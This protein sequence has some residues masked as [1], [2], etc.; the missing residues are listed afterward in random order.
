MSS[1]YTMSTPN[2]TVLCCTCGV[3]MEWNPSNMC[4]NCLTTRVDVSEGISKQG[5]LT[6]CRT[7]ERYLLP[8][9]NWVSAELES[10]ELLSICIKKTKGLNKVKLVDAG[11]VW[12]EPHSRRVKTKLTVQKEVFPN[13]ILQQS[14]VIEFVVDACQCEGCR[15][16]MSEQTWKASVQ[17]RQKVDHKKT[18]FY[19]EQ[20]ILKHSAHTHTTNIKEVPDGMDFYYQSKSH[21]MKF[22]D[23][24][25]C[26]VPIKNK[27]AAEKL[28]SADVKSATANIKTTYS[29]E[30]APVCKDD[31]VCLPRKYSMSLG[32]FGP[33]VLLTHI[34]NVIRM[35]DPF[36]LRTVEIA[37]TMYWKTPFKSLG[38][39]RHAREFIVL[40][41]EP[42]GATVGKFRLARAEIA[43]VSD[44]GA[45]DTTFHVV[46]HLGNVLHP[47][48]AVLG[49]DF[50]SAN[51]ND[52]GLDSWGEDLSLP[53]VVLVK[54]VYPKKAKKR[55]W[56]LKTLAAEPEEDML[57]RNIVER[58]REDYEGFLDDLE[59][60][61]DLRCKINMYKDPVAAQEIGRGEGDMEDE[62]SGAADEE[63]PVAEL[64]DDLE[65]IAQDSTEQE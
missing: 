26:V 64:L 53:D 33:F 18:F 4:V 47:G 13:C 55:V 2:P 20:L 3:Q 15:H 10:K 32:K 7:C 21:A 45:N 8:P 12:T 30:I 42:E 43:R 59:H 63:V 23:F 52:E 6:W 39:L 41:I 17:V 16:V 25:Q 19:L 37:S 24:L 14:F 46:T 11:F 5:A 48:D 34:A 36:T 27:G 38:T 61:F 62:A 65:I 49:Y 29:A 35:L 57:R 54:K 9:K 44:F 40:D 1:I 51:F 60:D 58:D 22:L 31:I 28:I 56:K 50:G